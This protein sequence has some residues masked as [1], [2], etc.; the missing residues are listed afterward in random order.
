MCGGVRHKLPRPCA[1]SKSVTPHNK[2]T[3]THQHHGAA[4]KQWQCHGR[5]QCVGVRLFCCQQGQPHH[6]LPSDPI[7]ALHLQR[8]I[9]GALS[10]IALAVYGGERRVVCAQAAL[11]EWQGA[12]AQQE[13]WWQSR[14]LLPC[15]HPKCGRH[16][17]SPEWPCC[18][19]RKATG[20]A[21][22]SPARVLCV[23]RDSGGEQGMQ[24]PLPPHVCVP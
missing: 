19:P 15:C 6:S 12:A 14:T 1:A 10:G 22:S 7:A 8:N 24:Q 23:H 13:G 9:C 3:G 16:E 2:H 11:P 5:V 4:S 17:Q 20:T 21:P 18:R